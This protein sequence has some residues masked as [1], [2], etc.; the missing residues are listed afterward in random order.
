M[1]INSSRGTRRH[2]D[3]T[4]PRY[5]RRDQLINMIAQVD[6]PKLRAATTAHGQSWVRRDGNLTFRDGSE[7]VGKTIDESG[8]AGTGH[9]TS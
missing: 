8:F 5:R 2:R 7:L 6:F 4:K 1:E 3:C 9:Q